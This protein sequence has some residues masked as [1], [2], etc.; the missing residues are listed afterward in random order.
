MPRN[1]WLP[2]NLTKKIYKSSITED[3]LAIDSSEESKRKILDLENQ[4]QK[5]IKNHLE[6]LPLQN[7]KF[8]KFNTNPCTWKHSQRRM[9]D[10]LPTSFS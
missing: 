5:Q 3:L 7:A 4:L 8:D 1:P 10:F 6:A 2:K 9:M